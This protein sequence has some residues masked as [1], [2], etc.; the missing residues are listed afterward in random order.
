LLQRGF[1]FRASDQNCSRLI[2]Y[3][4]ER[5]VVGYDVAIQMLEDFRTLLR[6][7][8]NQEV[9]FEAPDHR[10]GQNASLGV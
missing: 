3:V 8:V 10:V 6:L 4:F 5:H 7:R 2:R 9:I 1:R